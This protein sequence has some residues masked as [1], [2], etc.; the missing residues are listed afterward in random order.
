M[1]LASTAM[2]SPSMLITAVLVV[3]LRTGARHHLDMVLCER[4][5][6]LRERDAL[7]HLGGNARRVFVAAPQL[8]AG[9]LLCAQDGA[10]AMRHQHSMSLACTARLLSRGQQPGH[11]RLIVCSLQP[12]AACWLCSWHLVIACKACFTACTPCRCMP[13]QRRA[14]MHLCAAQRCPRA[15]PSAAACSPGACAS[16]PTAAAWLRRPPLPRR[17]RRRRTS[18]KRKWTGSWT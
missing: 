13:Q 8:S 11:R 15:V 1:L 4:S 5:S 3:Y 10:R 17:P 14:H 18:I 12:T 16:A 6:C 2:K 7:A 9:R